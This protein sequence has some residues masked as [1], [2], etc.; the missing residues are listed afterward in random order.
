LLNYDKLKKTIAMMTFKF[1]YAG[2]IL[3]T[4]ILFAGCSHKKKQHQQAKQEQQNRIQ[5][6]RADSLR[7]V[8]QRRD[9]LQRA[10]RDSM[11]AVRKK[12]KQQSGISLQ[13]QGSYTIQ[14]AAWR[15]TAKAKREAQK[16]KK[17]GFKNAYTVTYNDST[18]GN[19]WY[20]VRLGYTGSLAKAAKVQQQIQQKY[21]AKS[22][23]AD[24]R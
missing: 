3:M 24:S 23:I 16:W 2:F 4:A 12:N 13:K 7:Q 8:Q 11:A 20:R 15:S 14:V 6:K 9:S 1:K 5:Q 21:H 10:R 19:V 17:R 18:P 22:W